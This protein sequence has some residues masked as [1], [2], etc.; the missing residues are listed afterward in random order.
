MSKVEHLLKMMNSAK[1]GKSTWL[2]GINNEKRGSTTVDNTGNSPVS[3]KK[4]S[5]LFN[6]LNR[7]K[8]MFMDMVG[9]VI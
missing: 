3:P 6:V 8:T 4:K 1:A 5:K 7:R 9:D 2:P